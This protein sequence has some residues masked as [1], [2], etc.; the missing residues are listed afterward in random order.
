MSSTGFWLFAIFASLFSSQ[1]SSRLSMWQLLH[2]VVSR[3]PCFCDA[4]S[5]SRLCEPLQDARSILCAPL[6][7]SNGKVLA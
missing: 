4:A 3:L 6:C 7:A 2:A 1:P 5:T